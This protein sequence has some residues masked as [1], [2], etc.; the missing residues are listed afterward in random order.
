MRLKRLELLGF[1]S[2]ARQSVFEFKNTITSVV[3]P[4]GSGKSNI[5][6]ALLF[7]LGEQSM[8]SLRSKRGED[9]I[10]NG[11]GT[12]PRLNRAGV[13]ITFDNTDR[14]F[15]LDYDEVEIK[16]VI[17]RD[18]TSQYLL[19]GS[20]IRLKDIVELLASLHIGISSH[21]IISQGEADR[22]LN[23]SIKE[24][25]NMIEDALGLK[26]YQFK[27]EESER[28]LKKTEE[29]LGHAKALRQEIAPHLRFLEKEVKKI[30][31]AE[32]FKEEL[33]DLY[34]Q[35][36][37]EENLY[38]KKEKKKI[39]D[40][41]CGPKEELG[42]IEKS[43]TKNE[44][45]L[46][47]I[48]SEKDGGVKIKNIEKELYVIRNKKETISRSLGR[49]EGILE[50]ESRRKKE[51]AEGRSAYGGSILIELIT[52]KAFREN[53]REIVSRA[54]NISDPLSLRSIIKNIQ[55]VVEIFWEKNAA[56][57]DKVAVEREGMSTHEYT[58]TEKR[59]KETEQSLVS[60]NQNEIKLHDKYLQAKELLEQGQDVWHAIEKKL[61]DLRTRR[62]E[63]VTRLELISVK[64][65]KIQ[66]EEEGLKREMVEA[67]HYVG[68]NIENIIQ[69]TVE[70]QQYS[71]EQRVEQGKRRQKIERLKIKIEDVGSGG[72]EVLH[73]YDEARER[74][75]FL[76]REIEDL[77][78]SSLS[79]KNLIKELGGKIDLEFNDGIKLINKHFQDFFSLMFGGGKASVKIIKLPHK[80]RKQE[81]EISEEIS[82]ISQ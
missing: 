71:S 52:F 39:E 62:N 10:W 53:I 32:K 67:M 49:L 1:K 76:E 50:Y 82:D 40:E 14:I 13:S 77:E 45:E 4:N 27:R 64:S 35:Y 43:I 66:T 3:G 73:E 31:Q 8:K 57:K 56:L 70:N 46:Q 63:L 58:E 16:R 29:N 44:V 69:D 33:R 55:E 38:I 5:V 42:F 59:K 12:V 47:K 51:Q 65:E 23:A 79:L 41:K 15:G 78:K 18:G 30:H 74:D 7:V 72:E 22:I 19:N 61:F 24:R 28:K 80:T 60:I 75:L 17:F 36:L 34:I 11:S 26:I 54:E 25:R 37:R 81:T 48:E 20:A 68:K 6:E 9:L 21:H 2:F